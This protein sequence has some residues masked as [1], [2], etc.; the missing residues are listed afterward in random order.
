MP[1][2]GPRRVSNVSG[3]LALDARRSRCVSAEREPVF[4]E[5]FKEKHT[6]T[7]T[8][9]Q[10]GIVCRVDTRSCIVSS[11]N[12]NRRASARHGVGS[13]SKFRQYV[14]RTHTHTLGTLDAL[15]EIAERAPRIRETER[16]ANQAASKVRSAIFAT[17]VSLSKRISESIPECPSGG[18]SAAGAL[19]PIDLSI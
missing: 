3:S 18:R 4:H 9:E 7:H 19:N 10:K 5:K 2:R 13:V 17:T 11:V 12:V 1:Y 8:R 6:H 16:V 14:I 15:I